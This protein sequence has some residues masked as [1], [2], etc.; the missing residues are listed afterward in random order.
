MTVESQ[1]SSANKASN[2][3]NSEQQS[4]A[5]VDQTTLVANE[6][7]AFALEPLDVTGMD[8]NVHF[9]SLVK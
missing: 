3:E 8:N 2:E 6:E 1:E 5:P 7:E 4:N 9:F